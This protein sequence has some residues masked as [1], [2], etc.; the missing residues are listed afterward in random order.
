[1][2]ETFWVY[3]LEIF[4]DL[5]K[6]SGIY[7]NVRKLIGNVLTAFA[8]LQKTLKFSALIVENLRLIFVNC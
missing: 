7:G 4:G 1:M 8:N 3:S 5:W 2:L 6:S